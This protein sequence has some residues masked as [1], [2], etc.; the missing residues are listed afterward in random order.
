MNE[1]FAGCY[2]EH[3]P[4]ETITKILLE[5]YQMSQRSIWFC[6][7]LVYG[8]LKNNKNGIQQKFY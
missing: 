8:S 7:F 1:L 6:Q 4:S 2:V 3:F 5:R